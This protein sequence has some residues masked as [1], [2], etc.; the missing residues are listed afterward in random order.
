[1]SLSRAWA[2]A[3]TDPLTKSELGAAANSARGRSLSEINHARFCA[4]V[5]RDRLGAGAGIS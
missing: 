1:M 5:T 3:V 4:F 2:G